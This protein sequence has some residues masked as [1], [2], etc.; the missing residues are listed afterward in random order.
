MIKLWRQWLGSIQQLNRPLHICRSRSTTS[1]SSSRRKQVQSWQRSC[2]V[3]LSCQITLL[4]TLPPTA[5][6]VLARQPGTKICEE[7]SHV[8]LFKMIFRWGISEWQ[9]GVGGGAIIKVH[10]HSSPSTSIWRD[11][12]AVL[13]QTP[14]S[15][16]SVI[17][18]YTDV[19]FITLPL[20]PSNWKSK[21]W[22]VLRGGEV[23]VP[24]KNY[25]ISEQPIKQLYQKLRTN[26]SDRVTTQKFLA[27][28][29]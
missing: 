23:S 25:V 21:Q 22:W 18:Y 15:F 9:N 29:Q 26:L 13:A 24:Q 11:G 20:W 28:V 4:E 2:T 14:F 5:S 10:W 19:F 1:S 27:F 6:Q 8:L 3:S 7:D 12:S 17:I 16:I